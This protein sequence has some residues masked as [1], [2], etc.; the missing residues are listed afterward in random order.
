MI[1][2]LSEEMA[3]KRHMDFGLKCIEIFNKHIPSMPIDVTEK[4][5]TEIAVARFD[6][7]LQYTEEIHN[8]FANLLIGELK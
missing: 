7:E 5:I 8:Y 6:M 4:L 2:P 3:R 1:D